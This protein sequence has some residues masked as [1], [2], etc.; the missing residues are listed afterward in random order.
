MRYTKSS[1]DSVRTPHNLLRYIETKYGQ[2]YDPC[3]LNK[4]YE[5]NGLELN[6]E[7]Q[8]KTQNKNIIYINPPYSD[9]KNW[10]LKSNTLKHLTIVYLLKTDC[11]GSKYWRQIEGDYDMEF[12]TPHIIFPDYKRRI[13]SYAGLNCY[14]IP[15]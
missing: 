13:N 12:I 4:N 3:P 8:M 11:L 2:F 10:V 1:T 6:W 9:I 15:R 5:I 14:S 7:K